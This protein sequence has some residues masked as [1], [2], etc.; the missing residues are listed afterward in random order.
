MS[1]FADRLAAARGGG[2]RDGSPSRW[3]FVPSDQLTDSVGPLSETKPE[4][5]GVILIET[6]PEGLRRP[7]HKQKIVMTLAS[8]RHF[9]IEQAR[10][11]V[12]VEVLSGEPRPA[13]LLMSAVERF[14]PIEMMEAA[15]RE[16]RTELDPLVST[17]QLVVSPNETWLTTQAQFEEAFAPDRPWRMDRFYRHV[18][19]ELGVMMRE[20]KPQGGKWSFDADNRKRWSGEP[21]VPEPPRFAADAI[22][23]EVAEIVEKRFPGHP[24]KSDL[25]SLPASRREAESLWKWAREECLPLFGPYE[26]AMSTRSRGLFHTRASALMNNGRLLP[27][28]ILDDVLGL[29]LPIA[30]QEGFV[31]QVLGWR[32]FMRHVHVATDGF[33]S[34]RVVE[35]NYLDASEPLPAAF[36][37]E[38]SGLACL[39]EVVR[40]VWETGYGHHITRLMVLSNLATLLGID[41]REVN[42]WFHAAYVDAYDWVVEPNVLGMGTFALGD[43]FVTKP[44]VSGAAYIHKMSDYCKGCAFSP[45]NDCPIT[46]LY[47]DF[48]G[49]HKDRLQDNPRM[50]MPLRG[51]EK[52]G[53]ARRQQDQVVSRHVRRSLREGARLEPR[54]E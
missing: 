28:R 1:A 53:E 4:E 44:Y 34:G 21:A 12:R 15:E 41:P 20:G 7:D 52:R 32:E 33:R 8:Q 38:T 40:D 9:A 30:S 6:N 35:T 50:A 5:L 24:G 10:R 37:G 25:T 29:D 18:R 23:R 51:L 19:R 42:D 3:V 54:G 2:R 45:K 17:G 13:A 16:L 31:R 47:W 46:P 26:D 49:R 36:W 39:D 11:G 22:K 27:R 14:G 43:L 48:L